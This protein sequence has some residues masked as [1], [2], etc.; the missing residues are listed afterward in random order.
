[1]SR[2]SSIELVVNGLSVTAEGF[3]PHTTLLQWLRATGRTGTKEGCAEGDCGACTVAL[4][5]EDA[6]GDRTFRAVNACITLL[7]MVA[8]REIVTVEGVAEPEGLHPVQTAMVQRYGSQC[9]YCT[10]GFVVSMFEA[11][12]RKDLGDDPRAKIGDQLNGNLCRCTGYRPIRDAML[13]AL[14]AKKGRAGREDLF[15]LRLKK[16]EVAPRAVDYE[17]GG[18]TFLRPT[19]L[20][21]LLALK[22]EHGARA[23]LVAGATEIGVYIN[24]AHRRYPLLVS[25][26]GVRELAAIEK[27]DKV[28]RIGGNATL[29]SIEEALAGEYPFLD[30]ML[31]AF[32]SRQIRNRATLAGNIVTASPIGDMPPILLALDA[33]VVLEKQ[34]A[35][36][37]VPIAEFFLGYRKPAILP[38]E[39]VRWIVFPRNAKSPSR[40]M[41]S[42]KVSKRR[43]L[44][45]SI[46]A[47]AFVV[48]VE[49]EKITHARLA[50]GGVAATPARA[51][52]TEAFL[53]G[54]KWDAATLAGACEVL[55]TE[56]TPLDD[57]RS[58][59]AYRR[60]LIVSLFEK[61]WSGDTSNPVDEQLV[62]EPRG[63]GAHACDDASRGQAHESAV[64]HVTGGALYVDDVAHRREMLELWPVTSPHA[65]ARVVSLDTSAAAKEPGVVAVLTAADV[66]GM[67]DVGAVR[68]DEPLFAAVGGEAS[69]H[70]HV[71]A[72]V[73]GT[74]Y[75]ACRLAGAK[76][77]VEYEPLPAVVGV[78]EAIAK[79]S[80]HT[81]P[82]VIRRGDCD[83]ALTRAK[84]R[85][86]GDIEIGGQ[87][88]FYLESHA[89]WAEAGEDGEVFVASSTQHPSEVQAVVSHVLDVPRNK[90]TVQSPRMG[91]GF[92]GKETQGN[93]W[94]SYA[95]LASVKTK[96]PVRVQLDRDLDMTLTGKRHP[97]HAKFEIGFDDDGRIQAARVALTADGGWALD[98]SESIAD[99]GLFHLDNAYYLPNVDFQSRVAKTNVT[100]HTAFRGFGGPQGMV[101]IEEVMDRV[102]RRLGISPETVRERNLYR[103]KGETNTTHYGQELADQRIPEIWSR[104]VASS[105]LVERRKSVAAF[106]AA[107]AG[108]KRGLAITP[109]KFGIS[110][111]ATWLNQAGALVLIYRDGTV[112][113]NHGGT[114][115]G[116]G[117]YTKMLGVAM[118][119]LGVPAS[120][121]RVMKTQTDKVPNTS[122]TAASSGADLNGQAVK[123]ACEQLKERL[124]AVAAELL[125]SE[126]S[127]LVPP[128]AVLFEDGKCRAPQAPG[129][130]VDWARVVDRA[131]MKQIQ[132]S[133][134]GFYRTPGIGYDRS[135]G[136]GKPFYYFA[137]GAAVTEVEVDG[138]TGMK[139]VRAVDILHDVG[140]SL[141]PGVDRGQIEGAFVQG[142]GWL[143][144]E[145]LKWNKDG[146]LLTH[147]A[148]TYQIPAIGDTP[149]RFDVELLA[150]AAQPGVIHGSKAVGE[151]PLMLAISVREAIRDAVA[152]FGAPGG[153]VPL[154]CPATHEAIRAAI[155]TRLDTQTVSRAAE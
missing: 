13:D 52:K 67:N 154:R 119:E 54:K 65:R 113:V 131:Y 148:S 18:E 63:G 7:P 103:G 102:A 92:G 124:S 48:D 104:L 106:N 26:D 108:T 87:E 116:Q 22:A 153:E 32:A 149:E 77:K 14:E 29:T 15:Q 155:K 86:D 69:Y 47:A 90:V 80:Y 9:G 152:A 23:E 121:I 30:K 112:Q 70:G 41:D 24:K 117:L 10:P 39:V 146:K 28:W 118:R 129:A 91:G 21:A 75:E 144:G 93:T 122:A 141:N 83:G 120:L 11:Y 43:E 151:P 6:K 110:F 147:S 51:K 111:T 4:V 59:A 60:D 20:A 99:R 114:E 143:T 8:G 127:V 62:F 35:T 84:H 133:A 61:F 36:R 107:S 100:S 12:Y 74:S 76:V 97:F 125:T 40:K 66:P 96:R 3:T 109:V 50:F 101:V 53:V 139:R 71:V 89:A 33:D 49:A 64:G 130:E 38:D 140:E 138:Y 57:H 27:N 68:H 126:S 134:S 25:T 98:L 42:Y 72:I 45:I 16:S 37:T 44:D 82:H 46:T 56:F 136:R 58:G 19:S 105:K 34:G 132:L 145:E 115:M 142:M 128:G 88:H 79:E 5:E 78:R 150:H 81:Q 94:S 85:L 95:A 123:N 55:A 135:K 73:V 137:Y 2:S 1:M 17:A 31:W